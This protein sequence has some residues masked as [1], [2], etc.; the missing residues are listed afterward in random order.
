MKRTVK[1][2]GKVYV[3]AR[4]SQ[5]LCTNCCFYKKGHCT[6]TLNDNDKVTC[7]YFNSLY[8]RPSDVWRVGIKSCFWSA[9]KIST[10]KNGIVHYED[11]FRMFTECKTISGNR[12]NMKRFMEQTGLP[13]VY[14]GEI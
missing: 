6:C 3:R 1:I 2:D 5:E 13:W 12:R 4:C 7:L 8:V 11:M 10:D 9:Y 14:E